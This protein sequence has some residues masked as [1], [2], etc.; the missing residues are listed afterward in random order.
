MITK[1][2]K[3]MVVLSALALAGFAGAPASDASDAGSFDAKFVKR[4]AQPIPDSAGHIVMLATAQGAAANP[5]GAVDGFAVKTGELVDLVQGSGPQKAYVIFTK[6][7][8][9]EVVKVDGAVTTVMKDGKPNVT[10]GGSYKI[11]SGK[12][13]LAGMKGSGSYTGYFTAEDA[14]HVDWKGHSAGG[15]EASANR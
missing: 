14:Y 3:P 15:K 12:G 11:V 10:F 6:G 8:D 2:L 5:G 9:E 7:G 13:A 1:Q 4:D